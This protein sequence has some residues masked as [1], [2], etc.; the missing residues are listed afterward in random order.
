MPDLSLLGIVEL[1]RRLV[2]QVGKA[3]FV[4]PIN[5]MACSRLVVMLAVARMP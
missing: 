1:H 5:A 3:T 4:S 2:L